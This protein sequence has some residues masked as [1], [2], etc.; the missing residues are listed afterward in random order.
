MIDG[1]SLKE[2]IQ[3]SGIENPFIQDRGNNHCYNQKASLSFI[4][5]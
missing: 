2:T 5:Q 3:A 4:K 1:C